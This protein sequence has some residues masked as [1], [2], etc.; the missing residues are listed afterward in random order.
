[1]LRQGERMPWIDGDHAH[2]EFDPAGLRAR[3]GQYAQRVD[4]AGKVHRPGR[5]EPVLLG[6]AD[7]L[8]DLRRRDRGTEDVAAH[9]HRH[10]HEESPSL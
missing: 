3:R 8:D 4:A 6:L 5:G 1:L 9:A 10:P 2:T 7:L